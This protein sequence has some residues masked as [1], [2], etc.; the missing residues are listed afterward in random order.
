MYLLNLTLLSDTFR[1]KNK[2]TTETA[3]ARAFS[4]MLNLIIIHVHMYNADN[5]SLLASIFNLPVNSYN[6]LL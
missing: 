4:K 6:T 2:Q 3:A 5:L 1:C